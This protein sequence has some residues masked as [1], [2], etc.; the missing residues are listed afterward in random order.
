MHTNVEFYNPE[1]LNKKTYN[2]IVREN[3][4]I[5]SNLQRKSIKRSKRKESRTA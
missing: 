2:R 4:K 1:S 3:R 5:E